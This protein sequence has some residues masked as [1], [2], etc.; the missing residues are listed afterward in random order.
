MTARRAAALLLVVALAAAGSG[1]ARGRLVTLEPERAADHEL[2]YLP[3]GKHLRAL[4]FGQ[5]PLVSS[6]VYLWAIQ[7]YSDYDRKDR[8]RFVE[9]IFGDV[10]AELDPHYVD[11]YWLGAMILVVEA[12][13]LPG[14]LRL[15]DKGFARNPSA[16]VLPYLAGWECNRVGDY[17]RAGEYFA[18]AGAVPEAP[19]FVARL[20]AGMTAR[21]GDL[22][23]AIGEWRAVLD[24][25]QS[26]STAKDIARRQIRDLTVKADVRDLEGAVAAFRDARGRLPRSLEEAAQAGFVSTLP[27]DPDGDPYVYDRA[28]GRVSTPAGRLLGDS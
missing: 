2:L 20:R 24:D 21:A 13:D 4:S 8:Y 3:N 22:R 12:G 17:T 15:L 16:W 19:R 28:S 23:G 11:P 6:L 25:R 18:A 14:G 1:V 27:V 10:I 7:Y 26:D 5:A 9:H